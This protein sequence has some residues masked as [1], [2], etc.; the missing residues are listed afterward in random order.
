LIGDYHVHTPYC[1][2]AKGKTIHYIEAA[3]AA[4]L[5]EMCFTDHLG[6]YY[7]SRSQRKRYWDWGMNESELA[8]YYAEVTDLAADFEKK[9][10]VRVGLEIDF[11]AGAEDM[12]KP[13]IQFYRLDYLIGSIHCL[14]H[15]GWRH[16]ARYTR[17]NP[18]DLYR[19]Y[20]TQAEEACKS[21]LFDALGHLDFI[22]R[23]IPWPPEHT[24]EILSRID[25]VVGTAATCGTCI[26]INSNAYVHSLSENTSVSPP[27]FSHF[28]TSIASHNAPVVMGSDA[29]EPLAVAN[30][31]KDITEL[32]KH[33]GIK[34]VFVF[35]NRTGK[36]KKL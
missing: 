10:K 11:I 1:G 9:I 36:A 27:A 7:L 4:G 2:H 31:F 15:I 35:N 20:F 26:E 30:A 21:G 33:K 3:I 28:L 14:P 17:E 23:Y 12:L 32:L 29:H 16:L 25:E 5:K 18:I 8:R 22:W 19:E 24:D 6:R 13:F 34:Q